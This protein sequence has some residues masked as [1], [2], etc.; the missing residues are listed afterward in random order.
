MI[1][2]LVAAVRLQTAQEREAYALSRLRKIAETAIAVIGQETLDELGVVW[3]VDGKATFIWDGIRIEIEAVSPQ[4]KA[5]YLEF[6]NNYAMS[7]K[8][9]SKTEAANALLDFEGRYK[10]QPIQPAEQHAFSDGCLTLLDYFVGQSLAGGRCLSDAID[11]AKEAIDLLKSEAVPAVK[12]IPLYTL[13]QVL[14]AEFV[15]NPVDDM[16][17]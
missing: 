7:R 11:V 16:P 12:T 13:E 10:D 9:Q 15:E 14:A 4:D 8:V 3:Q 1:R 5:D 6:Q 2:D 17:F